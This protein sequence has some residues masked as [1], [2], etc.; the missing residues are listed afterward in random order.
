MQNTF[1]PKHFFQIQSIGHRFS[2]ALIGVVTLLVLSFATIAIFINIARIDTE[3]KTRLD[4]A[5]KL[6]QISLATPLWNFD[7]ENINALVDALFLDKSI[8]YV[9][10]VSEDRV[11]ATRTRAKPMQRP[12]AKFLIKTA[13]ILY[14]GNPIGTIELGIS[15]ENITQEVVMNILGIV[16]L[17][18]LI[19]AV[20]AL[21]SILITKRYITY[22][23]SKLKSSATQI[24]SGNLETPIDTSS[25]DEIGDLAQNFH[26]MR[27]FIKQL[28]G[29]L[30]ESNEK[31]EDYN[32]TLEQKVE[33]RTLEL[34]AKNTE[35]KETLHKLQDMQKQVIMQEKLAS[36]GALTAG[37]AH[38]IKNPLN[39]VNNFAE[40][41]TELT[42]ELREDIVKHKE[43]LDTE[44][45]AEMEELLDDLEQ[46]IKKSTNMGKER[47]AL[48]TVCYYIPE[49]S[50]AN[51][52]QPI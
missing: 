29:A 8:I 42:E 50:L 16:A 39:F 30:R 18:I 10:I 44:D 46:N 37:I 20:I 1:S 4:N 14:E 49:E 17:T 24:A 51:E 34:Q 15:R 45:L 13:D 22:P 11:L 32:R 38:E 33:E 52:H 48:S 6:A 25:Y 5:L 9:N 26:T 12:S 43:V 2:W 3:L 36:L 19:I 7:Y 27:D 28:F 47:I 21:T 41:S 31:L 35:L 40:L 23:L